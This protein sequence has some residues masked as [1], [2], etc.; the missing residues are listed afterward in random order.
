[1]IDRFLAHLPIGERIP[2]REDAIPTWEIFPFEGDLRVKALDEPSLP[3]PPRDGD[4]G[5]ASCA[6][7]T[8]TS[9]TIWADD[10][11]RVD[12]LRW[13]AS[14]GSTSTNGETARPTSTC[15]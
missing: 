6:V 9:K 7:C 2:L 12:R 10:H 15:G 11:W 13:A 3:E 4:D 8:D 14:P 5:P 1:M